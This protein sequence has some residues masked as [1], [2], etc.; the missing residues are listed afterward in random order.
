MNASIARAPIDAGTGRYRSARGIACI[1]G[2]ALLCAAARG[3]PPELLLPLQCS[4]NQ[5]CWIANHVDHDAGPEVL[6]HTC[7]AMS[8]NGHDGTDFALQDRRAMRD[9]VAVLAAA[10][11]VVRAVR[12]GVPDR[13]VA[14]T[15]KDRVRDIECGN[16]V[17]IDH[18]DQ[19]QTQYCHLRQG[20]I[21]V[22]V[23]TKVAAGAA[24]GQVGLSGLTEYPHLH[25]TLRHRGRVID[26]FRGDA[27]PDRCG[28]GGRPL[29]S[30]DA[31]RQLPYAPGVLYNLGIALEA[32]AP[33]ALREGAY[34][35][36]GAPQ[37]IARNAPALVLYAE[38]FAV[39]PGDRVVL[40]VHGPDGGTLIR[41]ETTVERRQA[42][43]LEYAGRPM[44]VDGWPAGRYRAQASL[45]HAD[46]SQGP[47]TQRS[48]EFEVR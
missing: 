28:A 20:T 15:G 43:R 22:R 27:A 48:L 44:P 46:G 10:A 9:G 23:G 5:T 29:W 8:Y 25:F 35:A 40:T 13:S 11:G 45:G 12:D 17:V 3:A 30:P 1:A 34:R 47:G 33:E 37:E 7:G 31:A 2:A 4:P 14:E 41:R 36:A 26:P 16:G 24:L 19:W 32:P 18:G 38:F 39:A 6:D 21:R 42:R